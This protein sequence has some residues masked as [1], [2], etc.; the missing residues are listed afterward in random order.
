[1]H[2]LP[3]PAAPAAPPPNLIA[4]RVLQAQQTVQSATERVKQKAKEHHEKFLA[5]REA[6]VRSEYRRAS[7]RVPLR[8]VVLVGG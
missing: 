1:M 4:R 2:R 3:S 5:E 6:H 7:A 8:R